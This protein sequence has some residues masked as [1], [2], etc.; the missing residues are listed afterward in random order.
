MSASNITRF[1]GAVLIS[2]VFSF[3]HALTARS[4]SARTGIALARGIEFINAG[5]YRAALAPLA[6]VL[7]EQPRDVEALYYAGL[8]HSRLGE[9]DAA[10]GLLTRALEIDESAEVALELGRVRALTDRCDEARR[11][12][13]RY[14]SLGADEAGRRSVVGLLLGC[15][16]ESRVGLP[17]IAVTLGWQMDSN[18]ILEPEHPQNPKPV[19]A[20]G[21]AVLY[22]TTGGTPLRT[23]L[24]EVNLGGSAYGNYHEDLRD[25]DALVGRLSTALAFIP[26]ERLRPALGY[27]F[28]YS[29]F[30]RHSY[31][32]TH[33]GTVQL[34]AREGPRAATEA[35]FEARDAHF[36][37]SDQF[38]DNA[39][40][41]GRGESAGLRQRFSIGTV[42]TIVSVFGDWDRAREQWWASEGWRAAMKLS[43]QATRTLAIQLSGEY[44][45]RDYNANFPGQDVAREDRTQTYGVTV[46]R[47][48]GRA[49]TLTLS[50]V[51]T[52]ND[53]NLEYFEY[54]RTIIGLYLTLGLG[55]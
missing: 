33:R 18:V 44:Q 45:A 10:A 6:S 4:E 3:T 52:R 48:L 21:R 50:G 36:W 16:G 25:Y 15:G 28:E 7:A 37:D 9:Y 35:I 39:E 51:R 53:S 46:S 14:E 23:S 8:A 13:E 27:S 40:R 26:W 32:R 12:F 24:F 47:A 31:N 55:G 54:T 20:D 11:L 38:S 43:W 5:N 41:T 29:Y 30:G 34:E 1:A 2:L 17:R 49:A 22:V 42:E 19:K